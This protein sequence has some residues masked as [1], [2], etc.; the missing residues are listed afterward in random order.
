MISEASY[1]VS[2]LLLSLLGKCFVNLG[3]S[4]KCRFSSSEKKEILSTLSDSLDSDL[5]V[6]NV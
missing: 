4:L 5:S 6:F 3:I 2:L 1:R